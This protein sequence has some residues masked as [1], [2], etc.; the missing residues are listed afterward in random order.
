MSDFERLER[1]HWMSGGVQ[2]LASHPDYL[3]PEERARFPA[4]LIEGFR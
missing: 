1:P 3:R 4:A 2:I